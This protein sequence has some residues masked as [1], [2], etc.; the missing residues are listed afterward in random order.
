VKILEGKLS[1]KQRDSKEEKEG[2]GTS[3]MERKDL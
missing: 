1:E 2:R 3:A